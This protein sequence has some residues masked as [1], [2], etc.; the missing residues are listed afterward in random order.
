[1]K[2]NY[3]IA[4]VGL[5]R[6]ISD[7]EGKHVEFAFCNENKAYYATKNSIISVD[8]KKMKNGI[9]FEN[10]QYDD[11]GIIE[12]AVT[13]MTNSIYN[14]SV[15]NSQS[16]FNEIANNCTS[17]YAARKRIVQRDVFQKFDRE[18][19]EAIGQKGREFFI[20]S[21]GK[22]DQAY[23][24]LTGVSPLFES[25]VIVPTGRFHENKFIRIEEGKSGPTVFIKNIKSVL[26]VFLQLEEKEC[27]STVIKSKN[28]AYQDIKFDK[29]I[30][31]LMSKFDEAYK[32][33]NYDIV[34]STIHECASMFPDS[35]YLTHNELSTLIAEKYFQTN[36]CLPVYSKKFSSLI[37]AKS[38][39]LFPEASILIRDAYNILCESDSSVSDE[40][41]E[42]E[43]RNNKQNTADTD[44]MLNDFNDEEAAIQSDLKDSVMRIRS[45][46][47]KLAEDAA[48]GKFEDKTLEI[49]NGILDKFDDMIDANGNLDSEYV[50]S[51][52]ADIFD[53]V[54]GY[55]EED[56]PT[57]M[58]NEE[59][60]HNAE[61]TEDV[62][63]SDDSDDLK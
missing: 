57:D 40:Q 7:T 18:L 52:C 34:R 30:V 41:E 6:L 37:V 60:L 17:I 63:D 2:N 25:G 9:F 43:D 38:R 5:S 47:E 27:I 33:K 4:I 32:S 12:E 23:E 54:I 48:D 36:G 53:L 8:Y 42:N 35:A 31:K 26:P 10:F 14:D 29:N 51:A 28:Q 15:S 44:R 50:I 39:E 1:M 55:G 62:G 21:F 24:S 19:H 3:K 56:L 11:S 22:I 16:A 46:I 20:S 61:G 58:E 45:A 49:L 13:N 59:N